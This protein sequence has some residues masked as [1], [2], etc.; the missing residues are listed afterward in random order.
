MQVNAAMN[1]YMLPHG[2]RCSATPLV[3]IAS[4]C[5][6]SPRQVSPNASRSQNPVG[7]LLP[8]SS[9]TAA[10]GGGVLAP[11]VA[12]TSDGD[13][14]PEPPAAGP[15]DPAATNSGAGTSATLVSVS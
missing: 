4:R 2:V 6:V 12:A 15:P 5:A 11:T 8:A 10:A 14:T 7:H 13:E 9:R 3:T 1:S